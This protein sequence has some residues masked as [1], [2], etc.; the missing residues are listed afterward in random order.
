MSTLMLANYSTMPKLFL[1]QLRQREFR[2]PSSCE[3]LSFIKLTWLP[4]SR[5]SQ[6]PPVP[7]PVSSVHHASCYLFHPFSRFT[8]LVLLLM[9]MASRGQTLHCS[10]LSPPAPTCV[11]LFSV[12]VF[13]CFLSRC[14]SVLMEIRRHIVLLSCAEGRDG[15][16]NM[17][18]IVFHPL[19]STTSGMHSSLRCISWGAR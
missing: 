13:S 5:G 8:Q 17:A 10:P 16:I 19:L 12:L 15:Q 2:I 3:T 1:R 6:Y 14:L 18:L 7:L 9:I 4:Q 11:Y